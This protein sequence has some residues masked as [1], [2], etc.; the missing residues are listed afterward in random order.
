MRLQIIGLGHVGSSIAFGIIA[1]KS[2]GGFYHI[3]KLLLSD[4]DEEK[5]K[6]E[7]H[8]LRRARDIFK[9]NDLI[10]DKSSNIHNASVNIICAGNRR[11][12]G[13]TDDKLFRRNYKIVNMI[14]QRI[15]IGHIVMVTNPAKGLSKMCF[16]HENVSISWIGDRCDNICD[17]SLI[18]RGKGYTNWGV[19]SEVLE[20]L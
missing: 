7:L 9:V 1:C 13:E 4:T 20:T 10:I 15:K 5:L 8:D 17:A 11:S 18:L 3:D 2:M 12:P 6:S 16:R 14:C 19:A